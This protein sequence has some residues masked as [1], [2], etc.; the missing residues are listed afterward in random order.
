MGGGGGGDTIQS[1]RI[2]V[3]KQLKELQISTP[4]QSQSLV[5][6]LIKRKSTN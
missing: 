1:I 3:S 5:P 2:Q 4:A 6:K